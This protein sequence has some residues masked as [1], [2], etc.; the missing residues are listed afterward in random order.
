MGA[1]SLSELKRARAGEKRQAF[2]AAAWRGAEL[3]ELAKLAEDA[4][5]DAAEADKIIAAIRDAGPAMAAVGTL[6]ELRQAQAKAQAGLNKTFARN[7][8]KIEELDRE[9]AEARNAVETAQAAVRNVER[10]LHVIERLRSDGLLPDDLVPAELRA[11]D[12]A[13]KYETQTVQPAHRRLIAAQDALRTAQRDAEAIRRTEETYLGGPSEG[14]IARE[15]AAR[16]AAVV[17][18]QEAVAQAEKALADAEAG[19]PA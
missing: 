4:G 1:T 6:A 14:R 12:A 19:R 13:D 5:L 9:I 15:K 10:E 2:I 7:R 17:A 3:D 8:P 11:R 18:A 16:D